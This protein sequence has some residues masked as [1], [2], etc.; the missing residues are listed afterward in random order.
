MHDGNE[1][2][3]I[4]VPKIEEFDDDRVPIQDLNDDE[5]RQC[6]NSSHP[7]PTLQMTS[8]IFKSNLHSLSINASSPLVIQTKIADSP[9]D[10]SFPA[11]DSIEINPVAANDIDN[12]STK[13]LS[14]SPLNGVSSEELFD[15]GDMD[16]VEDAKFI[17]LL[18]DEIFCISDDEEDE[19]ANR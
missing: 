8:E 1:T 16:N 14:F 17:D 7:Q 12:S 9:Y 18:L 6:F 2:S 5:E 19:G 3:T 13:I 11:P 15:V 4:I 10:I